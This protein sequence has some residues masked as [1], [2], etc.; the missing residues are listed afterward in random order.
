MFC[1]DGAIYIA[2]EGEVITGRFRVVR[3]G[4]KTAEVED[5]SR[6]TRET[7]AME[8]DAVTS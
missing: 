2:A 5:L 7:L 1:D 8:A 6:H 3:I 4:E